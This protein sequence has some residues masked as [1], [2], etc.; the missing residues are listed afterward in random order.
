MSIRCLETSGS[1]F[2][3]ERE[4]GGVD[5]F[6][7]E[8]NFQRENVRSLKRW[9]ECN[10]GLKDLKGRALYIYE[11]PRTMDDSWKLWPRDGE[12]R[13]GYIDVRFIIAVKFRRRE[14]LI[15]LC[16]RSSPILRDEIISLI[17][18]SYIYIYMSLLRRLNLKIALLP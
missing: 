13:I 1:C 15:S 17:A 8:T 5:E 9:K 3:R 7:L 4:S 6:C 14:R 18:S 11:T 12:Q 10:W 2:E 16:E